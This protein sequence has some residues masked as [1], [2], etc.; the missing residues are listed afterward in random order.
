MEET[1][2]PSQPRRLPT[3]Y[4]A[5]RN[6]KWRDTERFDNV[7]GPRYQQ[8]RYPSR[9][10][11]FPE[12]ENISNSNCTLPYHRARRGYRVLATIEHRCNRTEIFALRLGTIHLSLRDKQ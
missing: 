4:R 7:R 2:I 11:V 12:V 6:R 5:E 3:P 9:V 8:R 1:E 10:C